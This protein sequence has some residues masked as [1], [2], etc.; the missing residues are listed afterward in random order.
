MA[1]PG[2]LSEFRR[3]I[4]EPIFHKRNNWMEERRDYKDR[5]YPIRDYE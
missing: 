4:P 3:G 1:P 2:I 5:V